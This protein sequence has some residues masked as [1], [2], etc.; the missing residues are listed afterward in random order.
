MQPTTL[1]AGLSIASSILGYQSAVKTIAM[2]KEAVLSAIKINKEDY[3][4]RIEVSYQ[5]E[6]AINR[7]VGTMLSLRGLDA[8]KAE[9]RLR[10]SVASTGLT[11]GSVEEVVAQTD[12]DMILDSQ[13]IISRGRQSKLDLARARL[14]D[15]MSFRN[16]GASQAE[17]LAGAGGS[18]EALMAGLSSGLG[19]FMNIQQISGQS[20]RATTIDGTG[21]GSQPIINTRTSPRIMSP[22]PAPTETFF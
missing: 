17:Q 11:G 14:S 20:M 2:K 16:V 8:M 21:G 22:L 7:E 10:A 13:I 5:Q 4:Q 9:A 6:E 12:Y 1:S 3:M 19:A 18:A 15:F